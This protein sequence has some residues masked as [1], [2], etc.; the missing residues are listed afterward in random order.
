[1]DDGTRYIRLHD[2]SSAAPPTTSL[3]MSADN[4]SRLGGSWPKAVIPVEPLAYSA[5]DNDRK[6]TSVV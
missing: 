2:G 5:A 4:I 6:V 3:P 1:M